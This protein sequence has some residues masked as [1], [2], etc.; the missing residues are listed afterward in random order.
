MTMLTIFSLLLTSSTFNIWLPICD[1]WNFKVHIS[2][3]FLAK[4]ACDGT[5]GLRLGLQHGKT[6]V[7]T[8]SLRLFPITPI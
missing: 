7:H 2:L 1:I 5:H 3:A 4:L 6:L 8:L